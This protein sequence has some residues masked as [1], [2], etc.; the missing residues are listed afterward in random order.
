MPAGIFPA[1]TK[2]TGMGKGTVSKMD[3]IAVTRQIPMLAVESVV[4]CQ[5][6]YFPHQQTVQEWERGGGSA[7]SAS[8]NDSCLILDIEMTL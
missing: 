4:Q 1:S 7:S 3:L 5:L 8:P 2:N 6:A